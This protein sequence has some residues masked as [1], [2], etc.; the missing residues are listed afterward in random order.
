MIM[1]GLAGVTG[2]VVRMS[3]FTL[4]LTPGEHKYSRNLLDHLPE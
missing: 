2:A 4:M 3:A 1:H